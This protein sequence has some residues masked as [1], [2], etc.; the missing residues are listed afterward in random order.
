MRDRTNRAPRTPRPDPLL[1]ITTTQNPTPSPT[2]RTQPAGTIRA[3]QLPSHQSAFDFERIGSY[4]LQQC[5]RASGRTL[6]FTG[7][8]ENREG[9]CAF[10]RN[11]VPRTPTTA[12]RS[13]PAQPSPPSKSLH[14]PRVLNQ[15][16]AQHLSRHLRRELRRQ[17]HRL[18]RPIH[19]SGR[20]H[21]THRATRHKE[22]PGQR[23]PNVANKGFEIYRGFTLHDPR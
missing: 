3:L 23:A 7:K 1:R 22:V 5:L 12:A 17:P 14:Q 13:C 10:S 6:P 11:T 8:S 4:N 20:H 18:V 21:R 9:P 2:P 15:N 16:G 19:R